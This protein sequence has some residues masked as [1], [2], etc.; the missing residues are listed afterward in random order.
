MNGAAVSFRCCSFLPHKLLEF[1]MS[2]TV[3][4]YVAQIDLELTHY[5]TQIDL[6]IT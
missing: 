6:L 4:P 1:Q 2:R 5:I 3:L